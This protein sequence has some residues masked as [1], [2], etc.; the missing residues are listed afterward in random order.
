MMADT[1]QNDAL[2]YQHDVDPFPESRLTAL[3]RLECRE[4]RIGAKIR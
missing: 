2:P 4:N 1:I 3:H